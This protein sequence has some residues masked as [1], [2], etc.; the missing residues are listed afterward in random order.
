MSPVALTA[1]GLSEVS[2]YSDVVRARLLALAG[3][4][5]GITSGGIVHCGCDAAL[6]EFC[7]PR[8][9]TF[10]TGLLVVIGRSTVACQR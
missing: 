8:L 9:A 1:H 3:I 7:D 2:V 10:V 6:H 5:M 4:I